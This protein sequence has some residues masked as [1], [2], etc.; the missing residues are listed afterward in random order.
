MTTNIGQTLLDHPE[1]RMLN[2]RWKPMSVFTIL[3]ESNFHSTPLSET[4][5]V[6]THCCD[7]SCMV[8]QWRM[9]DIGKRSELFQRLFANGDAF[10][11]LVFA[12]RIHDRCG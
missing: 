11:Q 12:S 10:G 6:P 3:D 7:K 4:L 5:N 9:Q 2:I 1:Q 8:Q